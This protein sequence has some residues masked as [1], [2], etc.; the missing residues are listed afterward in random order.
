M[1]I[2]KN[3]V[4]NKVIA[5]LIRMGMLFHPKTGRIKK[6]AEILVS[7]ITRPS[8]FSINSAIKFLVPNI[9]YM[10]EDLVSKAQHDLKH[11]V[12]ANQ[13]DRANS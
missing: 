6:N 5:T 3:S 8:S 7:T 10:A 9:L 1:I 4:I 12:A 13:K 11:P 2:E